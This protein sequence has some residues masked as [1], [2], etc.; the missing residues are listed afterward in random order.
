MMSEVWGEFSVLGFADTRFVLS[1]IVTEIQTLR[2]LYIILAYLCE[3]THPV[4]GVFHL[5]RR[6][7]ITDYGPLTFLSPYTG[8]MP[9]DRLFG[10]GSALTEATSPPSTRRLEHS[11]GTRLVVSGSPC[12]ECIGCGLL[13][14][15]SYDTRLVGTVP[16]QVRTTADSRIESRSIRQSCGRFGRGLAFLYF[17]ICDSPWTLNLVVWARLAVSMTATGGHSRATT[18]GH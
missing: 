18:H 5:N 3:R 2:A 8:P 12:L 17:G 13:P 6:C 4:I 7:A 15:R 10:S 9:S 11:G 16:V 14:G 1:L